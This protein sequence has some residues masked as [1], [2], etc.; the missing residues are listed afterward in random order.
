VGINTGKGY[1][2]GAGGGG[3]GYE[4]LF[5]NVPSAEVR[6]P[7]KASKMFELST[8]LTRAKWPAVPP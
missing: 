8:Q 2:V 4:A 6:D 7:V 3:G 1:V 5:P